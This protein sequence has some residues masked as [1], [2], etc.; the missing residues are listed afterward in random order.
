MTTATSSFGQMVAPGSRMLLM[1]AEGLLKDIK[2]EDF[3]K[4]PEGVDCNTP[5]FIFGHL[6]I[7]PE[8]LLPMLGKA[9]E[10][11]VNEQYEAFFKHGVDCQDDPDCTI[12]PPQAEIVERFMTRM[13]AAIDAL[14]NASDDLVSQVNPNE[15][16]REKLPTV[17][18]MC[19]FLLNAHVGFHLGQLSTWR[20]CMGLGSAM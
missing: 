6:A 3:G 9:D 14:E 16:M 1:L 4:K 2:P 18:V 8:M 19:D 20:R 15:N 12:Y 7:Y 17:G 10:A 11:D 13:N 5:A